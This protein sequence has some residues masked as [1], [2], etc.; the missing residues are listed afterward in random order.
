[1][2]LDY[3]YIGFHVFRDLMVYGYYIMVYTFPPRGGGGGW[4]T[5][6]D[7]EPE[8]MKVFSFFLGPISSLVSPI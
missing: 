4:M 1:M 5:L 3:Q 8:F 6:M 2:Q 7:K